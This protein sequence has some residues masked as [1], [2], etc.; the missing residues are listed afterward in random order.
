MTKHIATILIEVYLL[1]MCIY[2]SGKCR[3]VYMYCKY[4]RFQQAPDCH[5]RGQ[6]SAD[7]Q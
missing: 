1:T 4:V 6:V 5:K 2:N 3:V 7:S